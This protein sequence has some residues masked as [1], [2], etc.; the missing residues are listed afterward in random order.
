M[1]NS[2]GTVKVISALIV[3]V[4]AGAALGI[5]FAPDKGSN[6]RNILLDGAK[7]LAKDLKSKIQEEADALRQKADELEE[8]AKE[9]IEDLADNLKQKTSE[10]VKDKK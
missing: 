5:L 8:M 1:E 2:D 10:A 4:L 9:K 6:T 3:G 7:D